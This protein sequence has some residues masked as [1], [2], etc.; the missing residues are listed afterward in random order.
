MA[1]SLSTLAVGFEITGDVLASAIVLIGLGVAARPPDANHP[2]GHG[3]IE[4][5]AGLLVGFLL[6]TGG[7]GVIYRSMTA[8]RDSSPP[9]LA[10]LWV[11]GL[12]IVQRG[13]MSAVKRRVGRRIGSTS[14]VAD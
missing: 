3:R 4:T 1:G 10:A 6:V 13:V 5:V 14:L 12:T 7:T 9:G 8:A 11:L 2:Y